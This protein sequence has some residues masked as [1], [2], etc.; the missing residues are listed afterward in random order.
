[1]L[2]ALIVLRFSA[3]TA[4]RVFAGASS[5]V[6]FFV[7]PIHLY[8]RQGIEPQSF[9][10]APRAVVVRFEFEAAACGGIAGERFFYERA[11]R[12][13]TACFGADVYF[14]YPHDAAA[15][16]LRISKGE[17]GIADGFSAAFGNERLCVRTAGYRFVESAFDVSARYRRKNG[18]GAV[19]FLRHCDVILFVA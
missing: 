14:V 6:A 3:R 17:K 9:I 19:K 1:M 4:D 5:F 2:Y 11:A 12:A 7:F 15:G 18:G 16:F 10:Q 13:E 8:V